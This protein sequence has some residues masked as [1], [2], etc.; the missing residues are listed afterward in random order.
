MLPVTLNKKRFEE[1]KKFIFSSI[2][3]AGAEPAL[4]YQLDVV[5]FI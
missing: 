4:L 3:K 1:I 5:V 2:K